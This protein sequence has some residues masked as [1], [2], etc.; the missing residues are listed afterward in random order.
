ME[1]SRL[2][3]VRGDITLVLPRYPTNRPPNQVDLEMDPIVARSIELC[4]PTIYVSMNYRY[5]FIVLDDTN[6]AISELPT[7]TGFQIW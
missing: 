2:D 7:T 1:G 6:E 4:W 5:I 3:R